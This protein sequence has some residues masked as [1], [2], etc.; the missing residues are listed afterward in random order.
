MGFS[1]GILT[2]P[3]KKIALNGQGDLQR[4][5]QSSNMS[6]YNLI[7]TAGKIN[8]MAKYKAFRNANPVFANST[9]WNNARVA[10]RYGMSSPQNSN[11]TPKT[12]T[13]SPPYTY[14]RPRGVVSGQYTEWLR[15]EDFVKDTSSTNVGYD[16][17]AVVP[18]A[19][20]LPAG[21]TLNEEIPILIYKDSGVNNCA[22]VRTYGFWA[23]DR[24][25]SI[26]EILTG[27]SSFL[28]YYIT[29][30]IYDLTNNDGD[31]SPT[32][33][34]TK[35]KFGD[36]SDV[37]YIML[38]PAGKTESGVVF[39]QI[40]LLT[41]NGRATHDFRVIICLNPATPIQGQEYQILPNTTVCYSLGFDA[42]RRFDVV[43]SSASSS[44]SVNMLT[45]A[46]VTTGISLTQV[47][48]YSSDIWD[49]WQLSGTINCTV[50]S[51][52]GWASDDQTNMTVELNLLTQN[53]MIGTNDPQGED[54]SPTKDMEVIINIPKG[55]QT[56]LQRSLTNLSGV[57]MY[58]PKSAGANARHLQVSGRFSKGGNR[59]AF[60]N[61]LD[62]TP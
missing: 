12:V 53:G 58:F 57:Y 22:A 28:N 43:D 3:F 44:S 41:E 17:N 62:I 49:K 26:S 25:L 32:V 45:G 16:A 34:V 46:F 36:L 55:Q 15:A 37:S 51:E 18:L 29:F 31:V 40:P 50:S 11:F 2:F 27:S 4:A 59:K 60:T 38:C 24:S 42:E 7:K 9:A 13:I 20:E 39:P 61:T 6:Q 54:A 47:S 56:N 23:A 33:V 5:L 1:N 21:I 19:I 48:G 8:A 30:C 52:A 35:Y 10:A 14:E